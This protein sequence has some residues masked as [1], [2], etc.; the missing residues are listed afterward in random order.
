MS[1]GNGRREEHASNAAGT[2]PPASPQQGSQ[3]KGVE[4]QQGGD[5]GNTFRHICTR[6]WLRVSC[7]RSTCCCACGGGGDVFLAF[8]RRRDSPNAKDNFEFERRL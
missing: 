6:W 4:P 3:P 5:G 8:R 7:W 1:N 2:P